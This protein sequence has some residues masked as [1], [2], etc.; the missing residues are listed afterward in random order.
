MTRAEL[1]AASREPIFEHGGR[2]IFLVRRRWD[3]GFAYFM[4][5]TVPGADTSSSNAFD[6]RRL[7]GGDAV[8]RVWREV[9]WDRA[10]YDSRYCAAAVEAYVV[11]AQLVIANAIDAGLRLEAYGG[12]ALETAKPI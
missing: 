4:F 11:E 10:R 7:P 5:A 12:A 8:E 3:D 9:D 1:L 2:R 6:V